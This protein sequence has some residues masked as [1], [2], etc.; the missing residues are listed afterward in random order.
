MTTPS[1]HLSDDE[2]VAH[3][4]GR[5]S[6][7]QRARV[8]A[9]IDGCA[10]CFEMVA[11]L[12][13][14]AAGASGVAWTDEGG[15]ISGRGE[16]DG[17]RVLAR[18]AVVLGRYEVLEIAGVG[19]MGVVHVAYDR[20]LERRVALKRV[21]RG[22]GAGAHDPGRAAARLLQEARLLARLTHPNVVVIYD[23]TAGAEEVFLAMELIEGRTLRAWLEGKPS[24]DAIIDAYLEAARG[25]AAA[26]AVGVVHRDVKPDNVLV[27]AD[28]R[29][30]VTDFGLAIG[31]ADA[32][33]REI[34]GTPRYMAPEQR[35][36]EEPDARSDQYSLAVALHEALGAAIP[37]WLRGAVERA[38]RD[39]PS[40][41]FPSMAALCAAI[42]RGRS[43]HR[44]RRRALHGA[45]GAL[46]L[47]LV[48]VVTYRVMTAPA[49]CVAAER[50][51][52][53]VVW[54]EY[55]PRDLASTAARDPDHTSLW[56]QV[57]SNLDAAARAWT[58]RYEAACVAH[59]EE[60]LR[61]LDR[62]LEQFGVVVEAA[63]EADV[64]ALHE[65]ASGRL[66]DVLRSACGSA[67]S[68]R[69]YAAMPASRERRAEIYAI[70]HLLGEI[71]RLAAEGRL[72]EASVLADRALSRAE[73]AAYPPLIADA[74][75]RRGVISHQQGR[76]EAAGPPL[77]RALS[78]AEAS[79]DDRIIPEIW[80][81]LV[82]LDE[83]RGRLAEA[84]RGL[85]RAA[86]F[87]ARLRT[88][89]PGTARLLSK[90]ALVLRARARHREAIEVESRALALY[91]QLPDAEALV[92]GSLTMI[93][94]SHA[95]L[96]EW[97]EALAMH[98]R[99]LEIRERVL[100]PLHTRVAGSLNN[101][102]AALAALGALDEAEESIRRAFSVREALV[103]PD[104]LDLSYVH[105][106][107][108]LLARRRGELAEARA[109]LARALVIRER[110]LDASHPLIAELHH[111][112]GDLLVSVG[113]LDEGQDALDRAYR[114]YERAVGPDHPQTA[115]V[116]AAL[117]RAALRRGDP[118]AALPLLEDAYERIREAEVAPE[119]R[120]ELA[121]SLARC[122][123]LVAPEEVDR[124]LSL[125]GRAL[126]EYGAASAEVTGAVAEVH[127]WFAAMQVARPGL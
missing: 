72:E 77:E 71:Q 100:G 93:A 20:V 110:Y 33:S 19:G 106:H 52:A 24:V 15:D 76:L 54:G 38:T 1:A 113:A 123:A 124:A 57:P 13:P 78:L 51:L 98:R 82:G 66:H 12:A 61:C 16:V 94:T 103:G 56:R 115:L 79:G 10:A 86:A 121:F 102:G 27:G 70:R 69:E 41:R 75:L 39:A 111:H 47:G 125:A 119:D 117:G 36:G 60:D 97:P 3:L 8:D 18:G 120:A 46:S 59:A 40:E 88:P 44:W 31:L 80:L 4:E 84:D 92:A 58:E 68:R 83:S 73:A 96:G 107:L 45:A 127:A 99:A 26:H 122:V 114:S 64:A 5:S 30:R 7:E 6:A 21:R 91:P 49:A 108:G 55:G 29:V 85:A 65:L 67:A 105:H 35:R 22:R 34:A 116:Q 23:A 37:V 118:A 74:L 25:L 53:E 112:L 81:A 104:G 63:I 126:D 62:A 42:Q 9:H 2:L 32:T 89:T 48:A 14:A 50:R 101:I 11:A 109:H 43:R 95:A 28:G 17:H 87:V 90:R